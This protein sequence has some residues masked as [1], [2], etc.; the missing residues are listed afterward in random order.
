MYSTRITLYPATGQADA[1]RPIAEEF[2]RQLQKDGARASLAATAFA[3][4]PTVS[5]AI[6]SENLAAVEALRA[7]ALASP[8]RADFVAKVTP[9]LAR[10]AAIELYRVLV[11]PRPAS[12]LPRFIQ[13]VTFMPQL[14]KAPE[15]ASLLQERFGEGGAA[16]SEVRAAV[17][18]LA[19]GGPA[20]CA[21]LT[22]LLKDLAEGEEMMR[23]NEASAEFATFRQRVSALLSEAPR[24]ELLQV[25]VP[26][27]S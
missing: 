4:T 24:Q 23:R 15:L 9:L 6:L 8:A 5:I 7:R 18:T 1:V 17:S 26:F 20:G 16:R 12:S 13:R 14:G 21:V 19:S 22:V 10:N 25:A 11:E 27:P 2:V 3:E